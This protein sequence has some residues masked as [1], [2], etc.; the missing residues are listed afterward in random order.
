MDE[1][2]RAM[3]DAG[4]PHD[5]WRAELPFLIEAGQKRVRRRRMIGT[6]VA[7]AVVTVIGT[8]AALTGVPGLNKSDPDPAKDEHSG[9]Y[10]EERVS[11]AEVERRCNLVLNSRPGGKDP[12][13]VAGVDKNG[14]AVPAP[15]S[16]GP[17]ENRVGH[18]VELARPGAKVQQQ[19]EM[20]EETGGPAEQSQNLPGQDQPAQE[21]CTIPQ[22]NELDEAGLRPAEASSSADD[23][24]QVAD[25]CSRYG[26]YD[27]RGWDLLVAAP[28][29]GVEAMFMSK[30]G[31]VVRCTIWPVG[32][33]L[34]FAYPRL[35][36]EG[37][38]PILP[39]NDTGRRDP[40]RYAGLTL[41]CVGGGVDGGVSCSAIGVLPGLP[42]GYRI[43]VVWPDGSVQATETRRG[44]YALKVDVATSAASEALR[45][46]VRAP[47]GA[48]LWTGAGASTGGGGSDDNYVN[49]APAPPATEP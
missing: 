23:A 36:D 28:L 16:V 7:A 2:R 29:E 12:T 37:G 46:R 41:T 40:D 19:G 45:L 14:R 33:D 17:V 35:A 6:G 25:L 49:P 13:W 10:V 44:A 5:E 11:V 48:V 32:V 30:N 3:L 8:T 34:D 4:T 38:R 39:A 18:R 1:L 27:L 22:E 26:G 42:D 20:T 15:E 31:Y 9:V 43:E 21:S 24:E 47:D